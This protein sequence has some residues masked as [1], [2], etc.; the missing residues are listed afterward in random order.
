MRASAARFWLLNRVTLS[1]PIAQ[2]I[3]KRSKLRIC[4]FFT[5][6]SALYTFYTTYYIATH[7]LYSKLSI[8]AYTY[9]FA[10]FGASYARNYISNS[11]TNRRP[12]PN[13]LLNSYRLYRI[14]YLQL[15]PARLL[16][17]IYLG[18]KRRPIRSYQCAGPSLY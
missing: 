8:P 14:L 3:Q 1:I 17:I 2:G 16:S 6:Y 5:V 15:F 13:F 18:L 4:F 7:I 11:Y 12:F 9:R 10:I